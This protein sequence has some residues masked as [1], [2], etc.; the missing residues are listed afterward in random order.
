M[1]DKA[2]EFGGIAYNGINKISDINSSIELTYKQISHPVL[3][4]DSR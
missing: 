1:M 3:P 4:V 2:F